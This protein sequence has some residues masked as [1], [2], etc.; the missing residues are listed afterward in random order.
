MDALTFGRDALREIDR[1]AVDEFHIPILVLMENAGR[2]VST[3]AL[4][5]L[6]K[7]AKGVVVL[8][9]PGNNGG[10]GMVAAR[11]L[12]NAGVEVTVLL[13]GA[14]DQYEGSAGTQLAILEAMKVRTETISADHSELR[15]WVVDSD[16]GDVV[17]DALFGTG[18]SRAVEGVG[19]DVI[20]AANGAKR[21]I[22]AVDIPSGLDAESG[23]ALGVAIR[24]TET[25]SFC[26]LKRGFAR[27]KEFTGKVT[28]ADI[29]A[30]RELLVALAGR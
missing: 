28:V 25:V 5:M 14:R 21:A 15:D 18:L 6:H 9:G 19:A 27:G 24:A 13:L 3:A 7:P 30:P 20:R 29:G 2:A 22:L 17:V 10:D 23:E 26:G 11:H 8:A 4:R 1:R 12:H 16:P